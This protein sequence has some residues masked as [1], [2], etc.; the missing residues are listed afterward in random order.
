[1]KNIIVFCIFSLLIFSCSSS[2]NESESENL[3][4]LEDNIP[5]VVLASMNINP[6]TTVGINGSALYLIDVE[7]DSLHFFPFATIDG[8]P[9]VGQGMHTTLSK[10]RQKAYVT[11]GGNDE[12][13]L[14]LVILAL[15]WK[16]KVPH[17]K[18]TKVLKLVDAGVPGNPAN[19]AAC[20]PGGPGKRQEGHGTRITDDGRF[21]TLSELQND[22]IRVLDTRTDEFVGEPIK[23]ES[24]FAPHGLYPNPSG[25]MAASPSYWFD[26]YM[27]SLWSM[28]TN[29]GQL[30]FL[31]TIALETDDLQGSYQHTVRWLDDNSFFANA[32]QERNQGNGKSEQ[33]VWFVKVDEHQVFPILR[34]DQILEGVSD[35]A[36]LNN[37]LFAAEG[38]VAKFLA[39]EE[40]PGHVSVWDIQNPT[41]P[42]LL[43]RF[44]AGM[45]LPSDFSNAHSL[46][47]VLKGN[48]VYVES[49]STDYLIKINSEKL[50]V[51][52]IYGSEDGL[53]VPHGIY[54][55]DER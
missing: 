8:G 30:S 29:T 1:M 20:H 35:L 31:D 33:S 46:G 34:E 7:T 45:G 15:N 43:K 19:G 2:K 3:N 22:R 54:V 36:I 10:D 18:V 12:L 17:P 26:H 27:I 16:N 39:G 21:L 44:S 53:D 40:T 23:H 38:N 37:K 24:L 48:S 42:K 13:S 52:K 5:K 41:E 14:R 9:I 11:I 55:T 25:T 28:D 49:F 47:A 50:E 4:N 6:D 32:T 51:E